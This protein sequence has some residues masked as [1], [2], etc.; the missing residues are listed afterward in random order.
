MSA[1]SDYWKWLHNGQQPPSPEAP[2]HGDVLR[3]MHCAVCGRT[4]ASIDSY[5]ITRKRGGI[6]CGRCWLYAREACDAFA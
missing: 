6:V 5:A 3:N 1:E 2:N 4:P